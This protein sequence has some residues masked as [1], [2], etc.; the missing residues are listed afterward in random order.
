MKSGVLL[1]IFVIIWVTIALYLFS[2]DRKVK[3]LKKMVH[4][5]EKSKE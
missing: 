5:R 1:I 4:F 2:L 3:D